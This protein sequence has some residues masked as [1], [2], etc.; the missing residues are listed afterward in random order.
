[1]LKDYATTS[2]KERWI[3]ESYLKKELY[4]VSWTLNN[5]LTK[6]HF[7]DLNTNESGTYGL[8]FL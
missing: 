4:N 3:L 7:D 5:S 6:Q 8:N 2:F 1:M